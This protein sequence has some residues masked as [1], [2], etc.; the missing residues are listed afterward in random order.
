MKK[1]LIKTYASKDTLN[2]ED[3][4]AWKIAQMAVTNQAADDDVVEMIGS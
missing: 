4:L 1:H 2:K 3:Q